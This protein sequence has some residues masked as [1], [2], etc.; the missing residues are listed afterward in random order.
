MEFFLRSKDAHGTFADFECFFEL[1]ANGVFGGRKLKDHHIDIVL[2]EAF[3]SLEIFRWN[4]AF[5]SKHHGV[6]MLECPLGNLIVI[7]LSTANEWRKKFHRALAECAANALLHRADR[8]FF[9]RF[10]AAVSCPEFCI[11]ETDEIPDL[12]DGG[13]GGFSAAL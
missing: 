13:D 6:A 9:D 11:E 5:V 7:A 1:R 12:G 2:F 10:F 4:Q 3:Q 8:L